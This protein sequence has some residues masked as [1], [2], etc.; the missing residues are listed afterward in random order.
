MQSSEAGSVGNGQ[1][2][3]DA[4][5]GFALGHFAIVTATLLLGRPETTL[6]WFWPPNAVALTFLICCPSRLVLPAGVLSFLSGLLANLLYGD[7]FL[8]AFGLN[9][10]NLT[11]VALCALVIRRW[12]GGAMKT[13]DMRV[14]LPLAAAIVPAAIVSG[15]IAALFVPAVKD[16]DPMAV[17]WRWLGGDVV[18]MIFVFPL[19]FGALRG[20]FLADVI[21]PV[22]P[23]GLRARLALAGLLGM[24]PLLTLAVARLHQEKVAAIESAQEN[25]L[26]LARAANHRFEQI[27]SEVE[28]T[29]RLAFTLS[30]GGARSDCQ[31]K[32]TTLV[33][34]SAP[35]VSLTLV[36]SAGTAYCSSGTAAAGSHGDS[37]HFREAV[38]SGR[39]VISGYVAGADDEP[40]GIMV[41]YPR[42]G[43]DGEVGAIALARI[44]LSH[45]SAIANIVSEKPGGLTLTMADRDGRVLVRF[46]DA[47]T[48]IAQPLAFRSILRTS[49]QNGGVFFEAVLPNGS[50][51]VGA[52]QDMAGG[53]AIGVS[54]P[55]DAVVAQ[56]VQGFLRSLAGMTAVLA[57]GVGAVWFLMDRLLLRGLSQLEAMAA[58]IRDGRQPAVDTVEGG[59]EVRALARSMAA[60]AAGVALREE[61]LREARRQAEQANRSKSGFLS[62][63]SHELRTPLNAILGFGQMMEMGMAGELTPKQAEYLHDMTLSASNLLALINDLFDLGDVE[64]GRLRMDLQPVT[65]D[66]V[67]GDLC[68]TLAPQAATGGVRFAFEVPAD[69]TVRADPRRLTQIVSNL[70]TNAIKY[71]RP[72]GEVRVTAERQGDRIRL[73][74]HDNGLGIP[75][76]RETEVFQPSNRLGREATNIPGTGLGLALSRRLAVMM[77]G[78][79]AFAAAPGGGTQFWVELPAAVDAAAAPSAPASAPAGAVA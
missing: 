19:V 78:D 24:L 74:V 33:A 50:R 30:E 61:L 23:H 8:L 43:T 22:L 60:M 58:A 49:Q 56:A 4:A 65:L 71:N 54:F 46:P 68:A 39:P 17:W 31:G 45:L 73:T 6:V 44:G 3:L 15:A 57:A 42:L 20:R 62:S 21:R 40:A 48:Q 41:A 32:M 10:A 27:Q 79:I 53:G 34:A 76:G 29:A 64:S 5:F 26:T 7:P 51:R 9:L 69:L 2:G 11:E 38:A 14:L 36:D 67:V 35:V 37:D 25:A 66:T 72:D 75:P 77:G 18:S 47:D 16:A 59:E 28:L 1:W 13:A 70:I 12:A 52:Y 63:M 55:Y